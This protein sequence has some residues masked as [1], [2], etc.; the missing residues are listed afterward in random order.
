[1]ETIIGGKTD[2][3]KT[4][5]EFDMKNKSKFIQFPRET[6]C[7]KSSRKQHGHGSEKG[8]DIEIVNVISRIRHCRQSG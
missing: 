2:S 7:G 4:K 8:G 3:E 1:M 5:T 6:G